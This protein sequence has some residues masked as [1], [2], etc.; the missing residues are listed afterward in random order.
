MSYLVKAD[1]DESDAGAFSTT[2]QTKSDAL[3]TVYELLGQGFK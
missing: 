1:R 3:E 2:K